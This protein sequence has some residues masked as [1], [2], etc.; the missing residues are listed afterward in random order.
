MS[1]VKVENK[2]SSILIEGVKIYASNFLQFTRY[3]LFPVL[4]QVLGLGLIFALASVYTAKLPE[5]IT[6]YE[7]FNSFSSIVLCVIL[8]TVPGMVIFMKAF[9]DFL[10]AYGALN[11]MAESAVNT[12]KVYDFPAHNAI[13]T[14]RTFKYI[15]L[16]FVLGVMGTLGILPWFWLFAGILFVY[17]ILVFQVFTFEPEASIY[18]CFKKSMLLIKGNFARTFVIAAVIGLFTHY[19]FVEGFSVFFD[20]TKVSQFLGGIF[21]PWVMQNIPLDSFNDYMINLN[22]RFDIITPVK[23]SN[24]FIYQ[25]VFFIV[26]GLTLPLRSICWTLWY[27][28]LNSGSTPISKKT[29]TVKAKKLDKNIIKRATQ[30]EED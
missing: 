19:L 29:K 5:L 15:A 16:W 3:M 25:I 9:W 23:I 28:A 17:F 6:T 10:V 18:D 13:I 20:L 12:G 1:K 14:N 27:K 8:I 24:M 7:F 30:K 21:E 11:S 22:P 2:V 4:G 26:T